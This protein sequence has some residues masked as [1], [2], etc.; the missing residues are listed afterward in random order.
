MRD[1]ILITKGN[2][3]KEPFNPDKLRASLKK[4]NATVF[5]IDEIVDRISKEMVDGMTTAQIYKKAFE[6]LKSRAKDSAIK[7]SLRRSILNLGP[8]GFPFEEYIAQLF[9]AKGYKARTGQ[10]MQ[11]KCVSHEVDVVAANKNNFLLTEV[12]FHNQNGIKTDTKVALYM[13]ARFDDLATETFKFDGKNRKMTRGLLITNTKFTENSKKYAR[14]VGTFDMIS[15]EYPKKGNLYDLIEETKLHPMTCVPVLSQYDK[16]EL[17]KRGIVNCSDLKEN[18]HVLKEI[19]VSEDKIKEIV[20]NID[21]IC[22]HELHA[23]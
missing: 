22:S 2:G 7:Y 4:A 10:I 18:T 19:G 16:Q 6:M 5:V 3:I 20:S 17:L 23:D 13:K 1:G 12:K 21:M 9:T 11:G 14:C 8:T 15:W